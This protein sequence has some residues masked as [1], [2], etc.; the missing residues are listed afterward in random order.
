MTKV[1]VADGQTWLDIA[2]QEL[3]DVE[4]AIELAQ[5]HNRSVTGPLKSGE[6]LT[7]PDP[8]AS[9]R[10]II[11]VFRN[12]ANKP[13]SGESSLSIGGLE[14]IEYWAIENDFVVF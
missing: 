10:S 7:V 14:G 3:G 13:A 4:R 1:I 9:K 5:L 6:I 12:T 2:M 8:V 11:Q